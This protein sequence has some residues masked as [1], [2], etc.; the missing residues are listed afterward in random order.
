VSFYGKI[1]YQEID[2]LVLINEKGE[3]WVER[4]CSVDE[5]SLFNKSASRIQLEGFSSNQN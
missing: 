4:D 2:Y 3:Y 5:S 1:T